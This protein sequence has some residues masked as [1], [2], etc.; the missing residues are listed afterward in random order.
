MSVATHCA[1]GHAASARAASALASNEC[2]AFLLR[3]QGREIDVRQ[4]ALGIGDAGGACES[5]TESAD[6]GKTPQMMAMFFARRTKPFRAPCLA[7]NFG[8]GMNTYCSG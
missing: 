6:H 4:V 3:I 5:P 8:F 2:G 1:S 7:F